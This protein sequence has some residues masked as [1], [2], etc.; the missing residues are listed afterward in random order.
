[1]YIGD[2]VISNIDVTEISLLWFIQPF[3]PNRVGAE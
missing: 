1:M 2:F 3:N